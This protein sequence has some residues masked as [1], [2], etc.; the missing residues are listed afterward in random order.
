LLQSLQVLHQ[1]FAAAR[2]NFVAH[3]RC[4]T[5]TY[6]Y[7]RVSTTGQTLA[8]QKALLKVAGV[9]RIFAEKA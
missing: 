8:T 3:F 4:E 7:A 6:G 1:P 5:T 9:E 2:P